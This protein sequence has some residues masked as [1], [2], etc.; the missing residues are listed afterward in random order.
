MS[1]PQCC[2]CARPAVNTEERPVTR[3]GDGT[4]PTALVCR[5]APSRSSSARHRAKLSSNRSSEGLQICH[6]SALSNYLISS[7]R[8][9]RPPRFQRLRR[10]EPENGSAIETAPRS[11]W[12]AGAGR[13]SCPRGQ[14]GDHR[15]DGGD[16]DERSAASRNARP[17][18]RVSQAFNSIGSL[19]LGHLTVT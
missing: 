17:S 3:I 4:L 5:L 13:C 18:L 1:G 11:S 12:P 15:D 8:A 7:R 6:R 14:F 9:F 10:F 19:V 16:A 2:P